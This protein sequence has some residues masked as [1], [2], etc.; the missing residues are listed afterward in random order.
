MK[1]FLFLSILFLLT[2]CTTTEYV[3]VE[4]DYYT[5]FEPILETRPETP[6]LIDDVKTVKDVLDNSLSWQFAYYELE[7]YCN[8]LEEAIKQLKKA[9]LKEVASKTIPVLKAL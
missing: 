7:D 6:K 2:G 3:P 8:A 4:I 1:V 9:P 5:Q